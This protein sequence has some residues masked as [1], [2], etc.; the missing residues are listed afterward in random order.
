M[1]FLEQVWS[2]VLQIASWM[3]D[4]SWYVIASK[5]VGGISVIF[6]PRGLIWGIQNAID[7]D[8]PTAPKVI[9]NLLMLLA[10]VL[11]IAGLISVSVAS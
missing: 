4:G 3:L 2:T 10:F 11:L 9:L 6:F 7:K 8:L 1:Y 5:I